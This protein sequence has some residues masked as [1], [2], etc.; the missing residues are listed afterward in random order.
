[1]T[2][3]NEL[4][5]RVSLSLA[6]LLTTVT[7]FVITTYG[8]TSGLFGGDARAGAPPAAVATET[9]TAA[10][11]AAPTPK[12]IE[13]VIYRNE[14]VEVPAP[15]PAP[16]SPA[17]PGD[18]SHDGAEDEALPGK[19]RDDDHAE[20]DDGREDDDESDDDGD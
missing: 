9:V 4:T 7:A 16:P 13:Q 17:A 5:R 15:Q 18:D 14:Y 1:M 19:D 20:E 8:S 12:V 10:P 2:G 11:S 6:L 3:R